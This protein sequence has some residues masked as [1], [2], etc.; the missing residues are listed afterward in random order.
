MDGYKKMNERIVKLV[1]DK[2]MWFYSQVYPLYDNFQEFVPR[3][4][5]VFKTSKGQFL[6][7]ENFI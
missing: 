3:F 6:K 7:L 5:G 2:E 1:E 4:Y